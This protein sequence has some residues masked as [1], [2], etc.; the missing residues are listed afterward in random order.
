MFDAK[1]PVVPLIL[2]LK[3][4]QIEVGRLFHPMPNHLRLTI[5]KKAVMEAFLRT[6]REITAPA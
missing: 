6:F 5:G 1:R 4:R 2:T 3:H